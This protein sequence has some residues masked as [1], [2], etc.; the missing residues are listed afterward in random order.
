MYHPN[1]RWQKIQ[2][3]K[4]LSE[5]LKIKT[6]E[7]YVYRGKRLPPRTKNISHISFKINHYHCFDSIYIIDTLQNSP[8]MIHISYS[9]SYKV[10][11]SPL[12]SISFSPLSPSST[13]HS[14]SS[15]LSKFQTHPSLPPLLPLRLPSSSMLLSPNL[16]YSFSPSP[17]QPAPT[18]LTFSLSLLSPNLPL[19]SLHLPQ[20]THLSQQLSTPT[21]LLTNMLSLLAWD[22]WCSTRILYQERTE[23]TIYT[24]SIQSPTVEET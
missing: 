22:G 19:F 12:M 16:P 6:N 18:I 17:F 2:S 9:L 20:P 4:S 15:T 23:S 14:L 7:K 3:V 1:H 10:S 11:L 21:L 13:H 8:S 5:K 24:S